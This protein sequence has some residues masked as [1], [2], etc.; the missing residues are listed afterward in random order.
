MSLLTM[1]MNF[2][3]FF[4]YFS[5]FIFFSSLFS[6]YPVTSHNSTATS[7]FMFMITFLFYCC[8][9]FKYTYLRISWIFYFLPLSGVDDRLCSI[10]SFIL[11]NRYS[12]SHS[13][14][15]SHNCSILL[16]CFIF[17]IVARE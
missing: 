15:Y 10:V 11:Y 12:V 8:C 3:Q 14:M 9:C 6:S 17:F 13:Y 5:L 1:T 16:L 2:L 7:F 4:L